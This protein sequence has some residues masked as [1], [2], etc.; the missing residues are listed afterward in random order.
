MTSPSLSLAIVLRGRELEHIHGALLCKS[1][2]HD[3]LLRLV[4]M[5]LELLQL[6]LNQIVIHSFLSLVQD[7]HPRKLVPKD[8]NF[9]V[10]D[11]LVLLTHQHLNITIRNSLI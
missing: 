3:T 11:L 4:V 7:C 10:E 6:F 8:C 1:L 9:V 5:N 2:G